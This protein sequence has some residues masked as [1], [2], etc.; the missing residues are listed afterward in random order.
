MMTST[1]APNPIDKRFGKQ[2]TRQQ[3]P[4]REAE[5]HRTPSHTARQEALPTRSAYVY[6]EAVYSDGGENFADHR[7][8]RKLIL[9]RLHNH[10]CAC[11]IL[12]ALK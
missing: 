5:V 8:T 11:T 4:P 9:K 2:L 1:K 7:V 10:E 12:H 6:V 3:A